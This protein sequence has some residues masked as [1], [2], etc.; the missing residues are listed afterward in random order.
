MTHD[1]RR[2]P[3]PRRIAAA[4]TLRRDPIVIVPYDEQWPARFD[5]ERR[6]VE[7][8]L[9][10]HLVGR[11]EHVGSTAIPGLP[12]KP[13]ID[14]LAT[15][16]DYDDSAGLAAHLA[17]IGWV[18]APEP[19]DEESRKWSF[20]Y[21]GI[22]HRSHHLHIYEAAAP[23]PAILLR[24]RDHLRTHPTQAAEYARLKQRLAA[25]DDRDRPRY[26][27][28]KAPFI[29]ELLRRLD[30]QPPGAARPRG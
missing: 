2:P 26:R 30:P 13:I 9:H 27:A 8:A 4:A 21:P 12:A 25:A 18:H 28:G 24:F 29:E 10:G 15:I 19:G 23:N 22:A 1:T 11:V 14:M 20:C 7:A 3:D 6:L 5:R 17:P 16:A